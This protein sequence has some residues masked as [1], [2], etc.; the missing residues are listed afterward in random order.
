MV[1]VVKGKSCSAKSGKHSFAANCSLRRKGW[2]LYAKGVVSSN[3]N[4]HSNPG[5][6]WVKTAG[7]G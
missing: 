5:K 6:K 3:E 4:G 7:N 1:G 2:S